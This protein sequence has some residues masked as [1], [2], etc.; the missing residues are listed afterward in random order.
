MADLVQT[1]PQGCLS[2][3]KSRR[4]SGIFL[5]RIEKENSRWQIFTFYDQ[6]RNMNKKVVLVT[7]PFFKDIYQSLTQHF[8]TIL[9]PEDSPAPL[10]WIRN[11]IEQVDALLCMLTD[12]INEEIITR[13]AASRLKVI[14]QMAVGVDNIAVR[15]A[16]TLKIPVGHTPGVLTE[17][18]ADFAWALMM[19]AARR[20]V[21]S[22]LEV[23]QGNWKAWGPEIL[24]GTDIFGK[25]LG[26]IGFG[27][28]GKAMAFRASGF[29][30][31]VLYHEPTEK[32]ENRAIKNASY[33]SL[34]Q[35][36]EESDYVSLHAYLSPTTKGLIG[37]PQ[38]ARM[39]ESAILVNTA[40][41]AMVD[42]DA[43]Y[44]ALIE[45]KIAAAALDVFDPEPVPA[46]HPLLSLPNVI[47]TPHV[48]SASIATRRK[49]AEMTLENIQAGLKGERLP[50]CAN[51]QIYE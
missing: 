38:L 47:I 25:T 1:Q 19:C 4:D 33:V 34:E 51:P 39:K 29:Q 30:M 49:M 16:T 40:R 7:R 41:G 2:R 32:P 31:R 11:H 50:Y 5:S 6:W 21:E 24:C 15:S 43:L 48:A 45:K 37:V 27:R 14:S 18:T 46:G 12:P 20:V 10:D 26:L 28:I 3:R 17:T 9:W 35:L 23:K 36:L 8:D 13:G 44:R 42:H 22:A